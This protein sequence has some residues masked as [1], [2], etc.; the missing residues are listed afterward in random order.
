MSKYKTTWILISVSRDEIYDK[1][2]SRKGF[3][4]IHKILKKGCAV[5]MGNNGLYGLLSCSMTDKTLSKLRDMKK[6][7]CTVRLI[8]I[9]DKQFGMMENLYI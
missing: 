7:G 6:T 5:E 9:T 4:K 1:A 3:K 2:D 8:P